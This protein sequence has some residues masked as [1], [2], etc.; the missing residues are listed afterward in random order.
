MQVLRVIYGARDYAT[1]FENDRS[2]GFL[3]A[4]GFLVVDMVKS[5]D[6]GRVVPSSS[7]LAEGTEQAKEILDRAVEKERR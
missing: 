1:I 2:Y 5:G 6:Y 7:E 4:A 3:A